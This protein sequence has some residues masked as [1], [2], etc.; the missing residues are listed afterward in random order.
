MNDPHHNEYLAAVA[1]L[2]EQTIPAPKRTFA[3]GDWVS[4]RTKGKSWSGR[5]SA[6]NG[7][8][9]DVDA[10]GAWLIVDAKDVTH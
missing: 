7:N 10:D 2:A 6:I 5:I 1:G 3:V 8:R 4:G 9:L